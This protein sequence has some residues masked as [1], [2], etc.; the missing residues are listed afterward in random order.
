MELLLAF[1]AT[2]FIVGGVATQSKS[3]QR[4]LVILIS[5]IVVGALFYSRRII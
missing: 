5:C 3:V 4:P 1:L 2:T